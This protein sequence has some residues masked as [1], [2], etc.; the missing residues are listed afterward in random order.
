V[1]ERTRRVGRN[2]AVFREVNEQLESLNRGVA[3]V[4][5]QTMRI[6]CECGDLKCAEQLVVPVDDYERIR[7]DPALFFVIRGHERPDVE[8]V[9]EDA[10][11]YHVVR[12]HEGD[13][14]RLARETDP[15]DG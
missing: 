7:S 15:R 8:R 10:A 2:E 14:A 11:G 3:A 12:K 13:P 1:D 5:D 4:S 6:V 9:V